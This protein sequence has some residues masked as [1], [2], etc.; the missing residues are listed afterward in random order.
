MLTSAPA[1]RPDDLPSRAELAPRARR[2]PGPAGRRA[3]AALGSGTRPG[4]G[5]GTRVVVGLLLLL[6][7]AGCPR[8]TRRTLVPDLP[9]SGD[10]TAKDR[11]V[12]ARALFLRDGTGGDEFA[13]IVRDFPD[14]PIVPFAQLYAG[15]ANVKARAYSDA[16]EPLREVVDG[17]ADERLRLRAALYLGLALSYQG[18]YADAAPL[19]RRGERAVDGDDERGELLAALSESTARGAEPLE[20][21]P[22][23]DQWFRVATPIERVYILERLAQLTGPASEEAVRAAWGW[24]ED[25][26]GPSRATLI[27]RIAAQREAAGKADD[28]RALREQSAALRARVG[29]PAEAVPAARLPPA[30]L[31]GAILP[32]G[33]KQSRVGEAAALGLSLATGAADG[34]GEVIVEVRDGDDAAATGAAFDDLASAGAIAVIGPIE[35]ASVDAAAARA[36]SAG[37]SLLSLSS[38]PE[39]RPSGRFVFH[40]MHSAEARARA[41]ARRAFALGVRKFAMLSSEGGYGRAVSAAFAAELGRLG[42][43][44]VT[45]QTYPVETKSF[46]A[47]AKKL[48]GSWQAIFVPEQADRLELIAP[49][50][51]A[52]GMV[53]RPYGEKKAP[54]GRPI[55]LLSTAEGLREDFAVD[56]G[57]NTVGAL[58]APG[59]FADGADP[60]AAAFIERFTQVHGHPPGAVDAYAFDAAQLVAASGAQSR[61]QLADALPGLR[62]SGVT[63]ELMF[64]GEHRRADDGVLY[65]VS[66]APDGGGYRVH[67]LR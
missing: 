58:L 49:A 23:Y 60:L 46:A 51:A 47:V 10:P 37:V 11:F 30:G 26:Q 8:N 14:D 42:A 3:D 35:S 66:P 38:R 21:L 54:G 40:M 17:D 55:V 6:A 36:S 56:V 2:R 34:R 67:V 48:T 12:S 22:L 53:P 18:Q 31:V 63:G 64:D 1:L 29:L 4:V 50:L 52:A 25:E 61:A 15:M 57:R 39:E 45:A 43:T 13:E 28:A 20:A 24:L 59:F 44:L 62:L 16:E 27:L 32:L 19:L 65:T 33:G 7:F 41:L 9:N 5:R